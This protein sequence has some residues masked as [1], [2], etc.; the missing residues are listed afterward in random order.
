MSASVRAGSSVVLTTDG[1]SG[2]HAPDARGI[3]TWETGARVLLVHNYYQQPGGEDMVFA[4]ETALLAANGHAVEQLA[5]DNDAIV[6]RHSALDLARLAGTTVWSPKGYAAVRTAIRAFRPDVVHFHNTFPLI[7]PAG[8]YAARAEG[9]PVVQ[10]LHNFRLLCANGIF[11]RDGHVCEDCLGKGMPLPGL[12]HGCY[13]GSR[14]ASGATVTMLTAH[15]ALGTWTRVVDRY[16][17][18]GQF[19]R[20]KFIQG[21]LPADKIVVKPNYVPDSAPGDGRGSYALFV[22]RLSPE[23]G[24]LTLLKAWRRLAGVP[25]KIAGDGPLAADVAEAVRQLP[26]A[27]W[28]GRLSP[29]ATTAAMRDATLLIFP[30]EWYEGLPRTIVE[31]F[32]AGTPVVASNLGAMR[33]LIRDGQTGLHFRPGDPEDLARVVAGV[34]A[35]PADL[36]SMR[37]AARAEFEARYTAEANYRQLIDIYAQVR[38]ERRDA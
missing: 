30:S 8:Y 7:S 36:A 35:R 26:N 6:P 17:A 20:E 29:E 18:L 14:T 4:A 37:A 25:L 23:K 10:T 34:F 33:E 2:L 32:A 9:V 12:V 21:G 22:G 5:F 31:S 27:E 1:P 38:K 15:R 16:I 28:L 24:I 19:A 3:V 11:Y 13:R